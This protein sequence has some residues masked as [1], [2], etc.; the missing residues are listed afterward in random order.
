MKK[1]FALV[2]CMALALAAS[3]FAEENL[4]ESLTGLVW[5]F[6]SGAGAWSTDLQIRPD[7]SFTGEFHDSDMGDCTDEYPYGTVYYCNFSGQMSLKEQVDENTWKIRIDR[8]DFDRNE[9]TTI[10]AIRYVPTEPYGISEGD[11]MLL[12]R[13]GTPVS[14]LSE[15]MQMWAHVLEQEKRPLALEYWFLSSEKND[16]GFVGYP[17]VAIPNPWE[18]MTAE[19]LKEASGF[20]FQV[21]EGAENVAYRFLRSEGLAEMQF[22][23][24][25]DAFC[26]RIQHAELE[27][28][29]LMD[30]SGMYYDWV[31]EEPITING[32]YG[33][34]GRAQAD[35][36]GWVEKCMWYHAEQKRMYSLSV[37]TLD[38]DGLDLTALA[39]QIQ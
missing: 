3:A 30:S 23:L 18:D 38:P 32:C 4:F 36:E 8:L 5:S 39:E 15:D 6:S 31:N 16:S 28:G 25:G 24:F 9:K 13:P 17:L 35:S 29:Q 11:E 10:D 37:C 26:A 34:I 20:S 21:P 33:T 12:Y 27:A 22:S 14:V 2:L 19:Q 7:G 1:L